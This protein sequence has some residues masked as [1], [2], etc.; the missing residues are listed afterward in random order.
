MDIWPDFIFLSN[1]WIL[2]V[3]DGKSLQ[4]YPVIAGVPQDSII[5]PALFFLYI[6]NLPDDIICNIAICADDTTLHCKYDQASGLWQQLKL[7]SEFES[8][9]QDTD[10]SANLPCNLACNTVVI[11]RLV[12]P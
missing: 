6:N 2:G 1:R 3:L 5:G 4:D 8:D 12:N 11:S 7:A 10:S 9:P